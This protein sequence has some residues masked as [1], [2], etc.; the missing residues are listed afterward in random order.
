MSALVQPTA[1][2]VSRANAFTACFRKHL[3]KAVFAPIHAPI[4][5]GIGLIFA[6]T[7]IN[8]RLAYQVFGRTIETDSDATWLP[9]YSSDY[10]RAVIVHHDRIEGGQVT[11]SKAL[12]IRATGN[13]LIY[14]ADRSEDLPPVIRDNAT[15]HVEPELNSFALTVAAFRDFHAEMSDQER[16]AFKLF[17]ADTRLTTDIGQIFYACEGVVKGSGFRRIEKPLSFLSEI[18]FMFRDAAYEA[19][20]SARTVVQCADWKKPETRRSEVSTSEL[21]A[22]PLLHEFPGIASF[23]DRLT[24]LLE[25]YAS[26]S[27][28]RSGILLY[29]PPGTGKTML[30]RTIAKTTGRSLIATSVG[31]WQSGA[32]L[33]TFLGAMSDV[34]RRARD[35]SPSMIFIDELD[36][37]PDRTQSRGGE[38]QFYE[39]SAT[40]RFLELVDG[41]TE[42]G[43]VLVIGATNNK[44]GIDPAVLRAGR[45]G[46]HIQIN[47]PDHDAIVEIVNW[48]LSRA[49][50]SHGI[51]ADVD[52]NSLALHMAEVPPSTIR[53]VMDDAVYACNK[54]K[55][56]LDV[57]HFE[58]AFDKAAENMGF[59][60]G[61]N[62]LDL[63]R[64]AIHEAGHAIALHRF[65]PGSIA[66]VR[67]GSDLTTRG[68]V[69]VTP[70]WLESLDVNADV[71]RGIVAM[72]GRAAEYVALGP[73]RVGY[74]A[75]ADL[76]AARGNATRL[77]RNGLSPDGFEIFVD[78]SNPTAVS[79]A[80]S[81]WMSLFNR[82]A[83][84]LL[85]EHSTVLEELAGLFATKKDLEGAE[86][87]GFLRAKDLDSGLDV[88]RFLGS[89][90]PNE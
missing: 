18:Y 4:T 17:D 11:L 47:Y 36:S 90:G 8:S 56:P 34:F 87:H 79:E 33:G 28:P 42:R 70:A 54:L 38:H 63:E 41:F 24:E 5:R 35:M 78:P 73:G 14:V 67:L 52:P 49:E 88:T 9:D 66:S 74:G 59:K 55:E 37:L 71:A 83:M 82:A 44:D 89:T 1:Q 31:A 46:E 65:M 64:T 16:A 57:S 50:C 45:F 60:R 84:S 69:R 13:H 68:Y 77:A 43:D 48:Y 76:E 81:K 86:C 39:A 27:P 15:A 51:S 61:S 12:S 30:A 25:R 62:L 85:Q 26:P 40:N 21:E 32:H 6:V 72:S 19:S 58:I 3:Q 29:G 20:L 75:A 10:G 7:G 23:R 53:S 22:V 80:A 2:E